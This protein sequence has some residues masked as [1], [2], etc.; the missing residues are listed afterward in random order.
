MEIHEGDRVQVIGHD[1]KFYGIL[2]RFF[3]KRNGKQ[4]CVVENDEGICLIQ[5]PKNVLPVGPSE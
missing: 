3:N 2:L 1:Y 4:R 5:T